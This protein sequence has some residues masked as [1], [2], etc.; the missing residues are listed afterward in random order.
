MTEKKLISKLASIVSEVERIPKNGYNDFHG[1][2]YATESD[3]KEVIRKEMAKRHLIMIPDI[4]KE[5]T[6]QVTT[7][8]G[9]TE[10]LTTLEIIYYI[11]D[12]ETGESIAFKGI[13]TGQDSGDKAVYKAQTGAIKYA[14][15]TLFLV[16]TGQDPEREGKPLQP[17]KKIED[18][19][20]I[21]LQKIIESV[22]EVTGQ[23]V[24]V[25]EANVREY[26]KFTAP[27]DQLTKDDYGKVLNYVNTLKIKA[28]KKFKKNVS[29][30]EIQKESKENTISWEDL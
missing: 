12:G 4:V 13:G 15:T 11:Y 7:A 26:A 2:H 19:Q 27:F 23:A 29:M 30:P 6:R 20:V 14:L 16:P 24:D 9:K 10:H 22:S 17:P 5:D 1:Y 21:F 3:I 18:K 8:K 25:I 28:E